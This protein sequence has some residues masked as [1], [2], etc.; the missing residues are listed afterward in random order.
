MYNSYFAI[1]IFEKNNLDKKQIGVN[2]L[3]TNTIICNILIFTTD[4]INKYKIPIQLKLVFFAHN[5][6]IHNLT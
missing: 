1:A 6:F 4:F 2:S 3:S 5:G